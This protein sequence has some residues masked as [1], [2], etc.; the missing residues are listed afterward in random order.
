MSWMRLAK[1]REFR[2]PISSLL[3]EKLTLREPYNDG[4]KAQRWHVD[5]ASLTR[6]SHETPCTYRALRVEV[7][8]NP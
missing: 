4:C 5:D 2:S 8:T 3:H 1:K 7:L 6:G